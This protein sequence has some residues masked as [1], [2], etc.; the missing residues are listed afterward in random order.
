MYQLNATG[1]PC[2]ITDFNKPI[3]KRTYEIIKRNS[4]TDY[5]IEELLLLFQGVVSWLLQE[6]P[7]LS[8]TYMRYLP[9][10]RCILDR[11]RHRPDWGRQHRL[12]PA[13]KH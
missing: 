4:S 13:D 9:T 1:G 6:S 7:S 5:Y 10:K 12:P 11:L 8:G 2:L 3:I